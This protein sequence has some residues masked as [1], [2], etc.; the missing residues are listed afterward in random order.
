MRLSPLAADPGMWRQYSKIPLPI[1]ALASV[2]GYDLMKS[3]VFGDDAET[4]KDGVPEKGVLSTA[5]SS[6]H[7]GQADTAALGAA[8]TFAL[9]P[10]PAHTPAT[11]RSEPG[12]SEY[13]SAGERDTRFCSFPFVGKGAGTGSPTMQHPSTN[14]DEPE[15]SS[16]GVSALFRFHRKEVVRVRVKVRVRGRVRVRYLTLPAPP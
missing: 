13:P 9:E 3:M 11:A 5:S 16:E 10:G 2:L 1:S 6:H 15:G 7:N 8:N 14:G 12:S 4:S